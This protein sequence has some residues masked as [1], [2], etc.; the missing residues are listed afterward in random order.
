MTSSE[1]KILEIERSCAD[2]F[3]TL[4][5]LIIFHFLFCSGYR[6]W[7]QTSLSGV[8]T[9]GRIRWRHIYHP[10][11]PRRDVI[12]LL[13]DHSVYYVGVDDVIFILTAG[14]Q[15]WK[16]RRH[17][18][19]PSCLCVVYEFHQWSSTDE[20]RLHHD[21]FRVLPRFDVR[22]CSLVVYGVLC[23][24]CLSSRTGTQSTRNT[25]LV[26]DGFHED[27]FERLSV[28]HEQDFDNVRAQDGERVPT[29]RIQ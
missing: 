27:I 28:G 12:S 22:K 13:Y 18:H 26:E 2:K 11:V 9:W 4:P 6:G 8:W 3:L 20:F 17:R 5:N 15:W 29:K 24:D 14:R 16:N 21:D 25:Q 19:K 1:G 10:Y 7:A 23:V